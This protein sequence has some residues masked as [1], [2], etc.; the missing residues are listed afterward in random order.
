MK[1]EKKL[2]NLVSLERRLEDESTES[3][4]T[5]FGSRFG[6]KS[7]NEQER[8]FRNLNSRKTEI[9]IKIDSNYDSKIKSK[10]IRRKIRIKHDP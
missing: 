4:I 10:A 2:G 7:S 9:E 1:C 5:I 8:N 3:K 6:E